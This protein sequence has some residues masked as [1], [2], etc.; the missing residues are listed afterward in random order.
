MTREKKKKKEREVKH[1]DSDIFTWLV[2]ILASF[3][4]GHS[5][6][7]LHESTA[8]KRVKC[9]RIGVRRGGGRRKK[10]R[11]RREITFAIASEDNRVTEKRIHPNHVRQVQW[12]TMA[13]IRSLSIMLTVAH[14]NF[15][16]ETKNDTTFFLFFLFFSLYP[17]IFVHSFTL[18][19]L[20]SQAFDEHRC[21]F[22]RKVRG[23]FNKLASHINWQLAFV[24]SHSLTH[25]V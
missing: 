6:S 9:H 13:N 10:Y 11:L 19:C 16:T 2:C 24:L 23:R 12:L 22:T 21:D 4:S 20:F 18:S 1:L 3:T 5:E 7:Q 14:L 17:W 25:C 8:V 15:Q